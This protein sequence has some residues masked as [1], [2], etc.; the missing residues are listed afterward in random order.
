MDKG[1]VEEC[2]HEVAKFLLAYASDFDVDVDTTQVWLSYILEFQAAIM[3][4]VARA[5]LMNQRTGLTTSSSAASRRTRSKEEG[6]AAPDRRRIV[7]PPPELEQFPLC[8]SAE[9]KKHIQAHET[10]NQAEVAL[11]LLAGW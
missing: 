6:R 2:L 5:L 10:W 9:S 3:G 4:A 7:E 1:S 8:L 11:F